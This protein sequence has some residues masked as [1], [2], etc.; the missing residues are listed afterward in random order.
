MASVVA[1][2]RRA[3]VVMVSVFQINLSLQLSNHHCQPCPNPM[4]RLPPHPS[5]SFAALRCIVSLVAT[6]H[7]VWRNVSLYTQVSPILTR[8]SMRAV[9]VSPTPRRNAIRRAR[10]VMV[11]RSAGSYLIHVAIVCTRAIPTLG[12]RARTAVA[13]QTETGW[14]IGV[15][16]AYYP[17]IHA[18][19]ISARTVEAYR[20]VDSP[21]T[22]VAHARTL[23]TV[24]DREGTDRA[25]LAVMASVTQVCDSRAC[26]DVLCACERY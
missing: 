19:M 15:A 22:P 16:T 12:P 24:R 7:V 8:R 13:R 2:T 11:F 14:L 20:T 23:P 1:R 26:H 18:S 25:A 3:L 5:V 9:S 17:T 21:L 10:A 6:E 4:L